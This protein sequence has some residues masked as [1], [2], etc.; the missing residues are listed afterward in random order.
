MNNVNKRAAAIALAFFAY[1][2]GLRGADRISVKLTGGLNY[3][4]FGDVN[5]GTRGYLDY[6][7]DAALEA[8]GVGTDRTKSLH[9]GALGAI[10]V[11]Y[12]IDASYSLGLG[13]GYVR[14]RNTSSMI[15]SY[16]DEP[17]ATIGSVSPDVRAVPVRLSVFNFI[18]IH[19]GIRASFVL[20]LDTY[21]AEFRSS[22]VPAGDG[23]SFRQ[24]A[25]AVGVGVRYG[26]GLEIKLASHLD[27][28]VEGQGCYARVRGFKGTLEA[29]EISSPDAAN[30]SLYYWDETAGSVISKS[31]PTVMVQATEPS[32]EDISNVRK[33]RVDFSGFSVLAGFKIRL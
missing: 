17:G 11:I 28:V 7:K 21:F 24:K 23:D 14:A 13:V 10:D 4:A 30:G 8:G 16:P 26:A 9:T 1:L 29:G 22:C 25:H 6:W 32:G 5:A 3:A 2:P 12:K 15:I 27:F 20:G 33:A 31:Y 19:P 18:P